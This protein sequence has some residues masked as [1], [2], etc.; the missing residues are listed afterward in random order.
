MPKLFAAGILVFALASSAAEGA[1]EVVTGAATYDLELDPDKA[2]SL[3]GLSGQIV[4][5]LTLECTT[6][7]MEVALDATLIGPDGGEIVLDFKSLHVENGD[8]LE[9]DITGKMGSDELERAEGTAS[10]TGNG[11]GC[12]LPRRRRR[13]SSSRARSIF[14]WRC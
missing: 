1:D 11:V 3:S 10:R 9:F 4:E 6:Y 5:T 13:P 2:G 7:R 8:K 12:P 14:R